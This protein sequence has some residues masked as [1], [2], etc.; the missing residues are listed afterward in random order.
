MDFLTVLLALAGFITGT[1][2]C[3]MLG[4]SWV[5]MCRLDSARDNEPQP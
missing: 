5:A 2:L 1:S 4:A 3:F